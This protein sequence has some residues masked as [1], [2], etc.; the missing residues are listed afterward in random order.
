M[1][2]GTISGVRDESQGWVAHGKHS[3]LLGICCPAPEIRIP[4]S[5]QAPRGNAAPRSVLSNAL[6]G[7]IIAQPCTNLEKNI[8]KAPQPQEELGHQLARCHSN[9]ERET[10]GKLEK[11][12]NKDGLA[13]RRG[14]G[15]CLDMDAPSGC[16]GRAKHRLQLTWGAGR[17][18]PPRAEQQS[19]AGSQSQTGIFVRKME[20]QPG[21]N[22]EK[23]KAAAAAL[24][25]AASGSNVPSGC[26]RPR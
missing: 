15:E 24:R 5:S 20:T 3:F 1:R 8:I 12:A 13:A 25:N 7:I 2:G 21:Q 17:K 22:P 9:S 18:S 23:N 26:P 10:G 19:A 4:G 16:S 14:E 6:P 11:G